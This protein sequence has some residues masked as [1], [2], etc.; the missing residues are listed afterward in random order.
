MMCIASYTYLEPVTKQISQQTKHL[1]SVLLI[2]YL[3][4]TL[5][6]AIYQL[7]LAITTSYPE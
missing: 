4:T 2:V 5:T 6:I 1:Q 3:H 7:N